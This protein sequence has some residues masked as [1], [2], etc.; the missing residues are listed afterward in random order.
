MGGIP[1][2]IGYR[3]HQDTPA[4]NLA[5]IDRLHSLALLREQHLKSIQ[6][7]IVKLFAQLLNI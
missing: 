1:E 2:R 3:N 6:I 5:A 7:K 4:K